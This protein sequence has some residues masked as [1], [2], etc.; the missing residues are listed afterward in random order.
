MS[1][2]SDWTASF[3]VVEYSLAAEAE[4]AVVAVKTSHCMLDVKFCA[5]GETGAEVF[6]RLFACKV[7]S[8][9]TFCH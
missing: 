3:A 7:R 2:A 9:L 6:S 5:P 8:P 4:H 1:A